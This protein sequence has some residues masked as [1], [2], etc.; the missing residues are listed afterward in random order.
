LRLVTMFDLPWSPAAASQWLRKLLQFS[1]VV[2]NGHPGPER[3][4]I[5]HSR[6]SQSAFSW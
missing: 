5:F 2:T 4:D 3:S 6:S 1:R